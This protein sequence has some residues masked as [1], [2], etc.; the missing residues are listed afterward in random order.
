[1]RKIPASIP[2]LL[3]AVGLSACTRE[4]PI[5]DGNPTDPKTYP[6]D[7]P[8]VC[9][10]PGEC[11]EAGPDMGGPWTPPPPGQSC[12]QQVFQLATSR[13]KPNIHLVIDRS[14]SMS[15]DA[16]GA[17]PAGTAT[18][19]WEDLA[20]TLTSLLDNH[21]DQANAWGMSLFPSTTAYHSCTAGD[22][23]VPL[24]APAAVIPA[25]ESE[26]GKYDRGKLLAYNGKTPTTAAIQG[27][28]DHVSL[29]DTARNN[30]VVLMTDGMPNCAGTPETGVAALVA[31]LYAQSPPVRTFVIGFGSE[32]APNPVASQA[33]D[34]AMLNDWAVAGH[35]ERA[36]ATKYYQAGDAAALALA[37]S[38]IVAGVAACT[39]NVT[40]TAIDPGLVS[41]ALDGTP[42]A[43]DLVDGFS[44]DAA[45]MSVT[46]HGASCQ[47]LQANPSANVQIV[48]GC[49]PIDGESSTL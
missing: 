42:V 25:I 47:T 22:I 18:A 6:M 37:F 46:F 8:R 30:Y 28:I 1:M 45:T 38:D 33:T 27:V 26:I 10:E 21:G 43:R 11:P 24:G 34:P 32:T 48:Y 40:S 5:T 31:Q 49:P 7:G 20:A 39:F 36:G 23:A 29:A 9:V 14:G 3:L 44:Y 2:V 17:A 13:T 4:Q 16:D 15:L 19:K 12:G 41:A 35:T